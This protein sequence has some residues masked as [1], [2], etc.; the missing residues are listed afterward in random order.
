MIA[1]SHPTQECFSHLTDLG[2]C[3]EFVEVFFLL[4][5]SYTKNM[6]KNYETGVY[7]TVLSEN[8]MI[9]WRGSP[10]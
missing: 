8:L 2:F 7:K 4:R 9:L 5:N 3:T 10:C 1:L 6:E